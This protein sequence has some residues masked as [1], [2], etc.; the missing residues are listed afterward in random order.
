[1]AAAAGGPRCRGTCKWFNAQK[2]FGFIGMEGETDDVFVH[3]S[4]IYARGF[5]SLS[6]GETVEFEL[7]TDPKSGRKKARHV[8]GPAGD[9]VIG[10][11]RNAP[12]H[13]AG[14]GAPYGMGGVQQPGFP[15]YGMQPRGPYAGGRGAGGPVGPYGNII[16]GPGAYGGGAGQYYGMPGPA[17]AAG[18]PGQMQQRQYGVG[19]YDAVPQPGAYGQQQQPMFGGG[20]VPGYYENGVGPMQR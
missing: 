1:M 20:G 16:Q 5:R 8:T 3:Q 13:P 10:E 19:M 11:T 4:D 2:G 7:I 9:Y 14:G 17:V 6:E 15:G 12:G 18:Y